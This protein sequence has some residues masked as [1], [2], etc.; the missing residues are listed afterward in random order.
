MA[1]FTAQGQEFTLATEVGEG[2]VAEQVTGIMGVAFQSISSSG[3]EPFWQN[4][5]SQFTNPEFSVFL[6]RF[7]NDVNIVNPQTGFVEDQSNG[8]AVTWG[9]VNNSLFT[10]NVEFQNFPANQQPS[11]WWQSVT[12]TYFLMKQWFLFD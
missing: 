11:F 3:A 10:G 1:D 4:I 9:G 8:G 12:G 7:D 6:A 2:L 5:I